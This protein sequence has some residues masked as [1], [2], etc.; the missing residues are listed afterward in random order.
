MQVNELI[1]VLQGL[2]PAEQELNIVMAPSDDS[3]VVWS[4]DQ[5][6]VAFQR[7]SHPPRGFVL[8]ES[9]EVRNDSVTEPEN[10]AVGDGG[11]LGASLSE[12]GN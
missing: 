4:L 1:E 11:V 3:E 9:V 6:S 5:I 12:G 8:F 7:N 10:A 2:S